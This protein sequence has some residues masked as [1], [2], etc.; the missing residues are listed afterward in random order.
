MERSTRTS[1]L[2]R[3]AV[4]VLVVALAAVLPLAARAAAADQ[5]DVA[6]GVEIHEEHVY[7]VLGASLRN[8]DAST[9]P[10]EQLY[11]VAG[12]NLGV[13]WGEWLTATA[14]SEVRTVGQPDLHT[15]VNL[16]FENLVADGVYSVFW[17]T[18]GPDSVNP[19]CVGVERSLPL[20]SVD[21]TQAPDASSFVAGPDGRAAFAGRLEGALLASAELVGF[22]IVYHADGQTYGSLPNRGEYLTQGGDCRSSYGHDAMR[23][24]TVFQQFFPVAPPTAVED[25]Y[26]AVPRTAPFASPGSVL[27]ND[28][29]GLVARLD[30]APLHGTVALGE[31]GTFT[32]TLT[33][34]TE[35]VA[36][37]SFSYLACATPTAC[38]TPTAVTLSLEPAGPTLTATVQQPIDLDGTSTFSA[39]RGVIPV[40][41][42][43]AADDVPTCDLPPASIR[44]RRLGPSSDEVVD[45]S[46]HVSSSDTGSTFRISDCR[47]VYNLAARPLGPGSYAVEVLVDGHA[48]GS[49]T[50]TLA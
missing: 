41:F 34:P 15:E 37:D 25:R 42:A 11:N 38:S 49:A 26:D 22:Q 10:S 50:F 12:L 35:P 48:A 39:K 1:M 5:V 2:T 19:L 45:E 17:F 44:V 30:T 33:D 14:T 4:S 27:D 46:V 40:R 29:G 20:P 36:S 47:Y 24:L 9:D 18:I 23:H 7:V 43:L 3:Q 8:P 31:N 6:D 21:P 13:T 32:Y 28:S 16:V